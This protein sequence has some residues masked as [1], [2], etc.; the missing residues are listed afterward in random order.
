MTKIEAAYLVRNTKVTA[1]AAAVV[2]F[3]WFITTHDF[4]IENV[5]LGILL[6]MASAFATCYLAY[7]AFSE[8]ISN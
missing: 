1:I 2:A 7:M 6:G 8:R 5:G 3:V 4:N